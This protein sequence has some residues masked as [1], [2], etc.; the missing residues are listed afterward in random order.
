MWLYLLARHESFH[1]IG[2]PIN[3]SDNGTATAQH[4]ATHTHTYIYT[5]NSDVN[6][7][8]H[9]EHSKL[10]ANMTNEAL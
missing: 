5:H 4:A 2:A 3:S 6:S 10:L 8:E 1:K 7:G 9:S